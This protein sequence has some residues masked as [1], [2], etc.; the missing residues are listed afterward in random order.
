VSGGCTVIL[1]ISYKEHFHEDGHSRWPKHVAGYNKFTDL[2]VQFLV[3]LLIMAHQ[4]MVMNH[5]EI[6]SNTS[7][8]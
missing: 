3:V 1:G 4:I 2:F 8:Y 6:Q 5:L 7:S